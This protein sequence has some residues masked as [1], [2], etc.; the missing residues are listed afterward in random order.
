MTP[1]SWILILLQMKENAAHCMSFKICHGGN[2][3]T[4]KHI[5]MMSQTLRLIGS[6]VQV[7]FQ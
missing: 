3:P 1:T 4:Y 7:S 5:S 2:Y 6:N